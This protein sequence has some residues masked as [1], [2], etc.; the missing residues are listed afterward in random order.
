MSAASDSI[1][2]PRPEERAEEARAS[3]RR[4]AELLKGILDTPGMDA[5]WLEVEVRMQ[6]LWLTAAVNEW[7]E[8]QRERELIAK[9]REQMGWLW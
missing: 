7:H 2:G 5:A 3:M 8:A 4:S 9:R 6:I 1:Y